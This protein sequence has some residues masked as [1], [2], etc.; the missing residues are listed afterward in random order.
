MPT[1]YRSNVGARADRLCAAV[2]HDQADV[3][4]RVCAPCTPPRRPCVWITGAELV[5]RCTWH[6]GAFVFCRVKG[7][8]ARTRPNAWRGHLHGDGIMARQPGRRSRS[9]CVYL[10]GARIA[11]SLAITMRSARVISCRRASH[12]C[13]QTVMIPHTLLHSG[14]D[15]GA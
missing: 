6:T 3:F 14:V 5:S 9:H 2:G 1:G 10:R 13:T 15:D 11:I 12:S 4:S 7:M 8:N